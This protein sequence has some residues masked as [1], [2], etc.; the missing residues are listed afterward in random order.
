MNVTL[1]NVLACSLIAGSLVLSMTRVNALPLKMKSGNMVDVKLIMSQDDKIVLQKG[2]IQMTVP[3]DRFED[4][5]DE[6]STMAEN[7]L[8]S[9]DTATALDYSSQVL[10]WNPL[11]VKAQ[12]ILDDIKVAQDL[13]QKRITA[14]KEEQEAMARYNEERAKAEISVKKMIEEENRKPAKIFENIRKAYQSLNSYKVQGNILQEIYAKDTVVNVE[15]PVIMAGIKPNLNSLDLKLNGNEIKV[16]ENSDTT[17]IYFPAQKQ[18]IKLPVKTLDQV[19]ANLNTSPLLNVGFDNY[20]KLVSIATAATFVQEEE[21]TLNDA[22]IAC[23][24]YLL[25]VVP[26]P[27]LDKVM[28]ITDHQ[29]WVNKAS[30]LVMQESQEIKMKSVAEVTIKQKIVYGKFEKNPS[31]SAADV[32]LNLPKDAAPMDMAKLLGLLSNVATL[33]K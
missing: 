23:Y 24:V 19:Q 11:H 20:E 27:A 6:W 15:I 25:P 14:Q 18:Y 5:Q 32:E 30:N 28:E 7:A 3:K 33:S 17:I 2:N 12:K 9:G 8:L 21:I 29:L 10:I 16:F 26:N 22:T 31:L 1:K 13:E 4:P